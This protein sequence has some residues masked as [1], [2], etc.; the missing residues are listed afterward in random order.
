MV[1]LRSF[2]SPYRRDLLFHSTGPRKLN[3]RRRRKGM[4]ARTGEILRRKW[5]R[6]RKRK[7]EKGMQRKRGEEA[8]WRKTKAGVENPRG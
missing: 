4:Y 1:E 3:R 5:R 7:I 8:P 2:C 6:G